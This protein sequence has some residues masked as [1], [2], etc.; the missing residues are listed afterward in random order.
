MS[1]GRG[2]W[3]GV[4]YPV[5]Y[6]SMV[7]TETALMELEYFFMLTVYIKVKYKSGRFA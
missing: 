3:Y 4:A 1:T 7:G 6:A 5:Q 2:G